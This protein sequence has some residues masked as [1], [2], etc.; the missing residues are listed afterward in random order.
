MNLVHGVELKRHGDRRSEVED[1]VVAHGCEEDVTASR[2][3]N[4][5]EHERE[6]P[7]GPD[8]HR[9]ELA[10]APLRDV[11]E[12]HRPVGE[13]RVPHEGRPSHHGPSLHLCGRAHRQGEENHRWR[14]ET[15]SAQ[16][17]RPIRE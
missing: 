15:E 12:D 4:V 11:V 7:L 10:L 17:P 13:R 16:K 2:I 14:E 9:V 3:G 1:P 5:G 8:A 6:R